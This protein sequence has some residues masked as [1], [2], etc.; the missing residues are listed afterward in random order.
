MKKMIVALSTAAALG[1]G[2][3]SVA[4]AHASDQLH[5]SS[6]QIPYKQEISVDREKQIAL[7]IVHGRIL[8]IELE[9]EHGLTFYKVKILHENVRYDVL[10]DSKTGKTYFHHGI[11]VSDDRGYDDHGGRGR[12]SDD[13]DND[14]HGGR[15]RGSDDR[16]NDD[17]GGRGRG[18]DDRND[19]DNGGRGSSSDD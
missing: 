17:N 14:D 3:V 9:F 4:D 16:D 1:T 19:D 7:A 13:G 6:T 18:S 12:G 15:G 2:V 8:S 11:H 5:S 10:I